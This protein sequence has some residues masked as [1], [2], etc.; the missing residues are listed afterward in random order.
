MGF[1]T[2]ESGELVLESAERPLFPDRKEAASDLSTRVSPLLNPDA[3]LRGLSVLPLPGILDLNPRKDRFDSLVSD[4]L[5]D[6]YDW[7]LSK[8]LFKEVCDA[9]PLGVD[10]PEPFEGWFPI[11]VMFVCRRLVEA[12]MF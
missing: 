9:P 5:N 6:G 11:L 2:G 3:E 4:L 8:S 10:V 1:D 12:V 7:R